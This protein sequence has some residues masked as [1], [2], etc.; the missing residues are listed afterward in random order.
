MKWSE[1]VG[2]EWQIEASVNK[3]KGDLELL[4]LQRDP[5]RI[6]LARN[7]NPR[8]SQ[9][10]P[11]FILLTFVP[12]LPK[13]RYTTADIH[14][15]YTWSAVVWSWGPFT[16]SGPL[17]LANLSVCGGAQAARVA[18]VARRPGEMLVCGPPT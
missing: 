5:K 11:T 3:Q 1:V 13:H 18:Q 6:K 15:S 9:F 14:S 8:P 4:W 12:T 7:S 2:G 17:V 10:Q 16:R